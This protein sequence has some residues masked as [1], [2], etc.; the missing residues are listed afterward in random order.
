MKDFPICRTRC[1]WR[2]PPAPLRIFRFAA[3]AV[4]LAA[5][6][7]LIA[8]PEVHTL[9][10]GP[11]QFPLNS[12]GYVDGDTAT[13]AQFNAPYGIAQDNTGNNFFVADRD[14]NAIRQLDRVSGETFDIFFQSFALISESQTRTRAVECL[15]RRP[16]D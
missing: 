11:I 13:I 7:T 6:L 16:G 10:G 5:T 2:Q 15:G 4:L 3:W 14:N 9:T 12:A 1:G 8:A